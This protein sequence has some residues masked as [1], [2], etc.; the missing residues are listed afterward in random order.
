MDNQNRALCPTVLITGG[1]GYIG[2]AT[3]LYMM[4][5]GYNVVIIDK[6][7]PKSQ[8]NNVIFIEADYA[9]QDKLDYIFSNYKIDAVIHFAGSI[10]VGLSVKD[11][12]LFY[13]NNVAKTLKLL[14]SMKKHKINKI[15]FSSSCAV[16]GTPKTE[17]LKE[18]HARDPISPYGRTKYIIEMILEDYAQAYGLKAIALRYFNAAGALPEFFIGEMHEPE[19]HVIPLIFDAIYN[20]KQ[21]KIFG[22]DY[23]TRDGTCIRDYLHIYDLA[24]AHY[25]AVKYLENCSGF[26]AFNLGTGIGHSVR[27]LISCVENITG[28]K[29]DV[30]EDARRVGD[31]AQLVADASKANNILGWQPSMSKLKEIISSAHEF[32]K[33]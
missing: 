4:Q 2:S 7:K 33:K 30:I 17:Y 9:D 19:T 21:F 20:N 10:E 11:P 5:N 25:L 23:T 18:D 12:E 8:V 24:K 3:V 15:V 16:Y 31:P 26:E 29:L 1:S 27:E 32:H 28:K 6:V 14:E 13:D 22:T